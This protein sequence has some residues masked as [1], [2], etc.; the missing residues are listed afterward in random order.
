MKLKAFNRLHKRSISLFIFIVNI[1]S[2]SVKN[3]GYKAKKSFFFLKKD[4]AEPIDFCLI[5]C[6]LYN[7]WVNVYTF[8]IPEETHE[9]LHRLVGKKKMSSEDKE[10]FLRRH[11]R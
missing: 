6:T 7:A 4:Y 8:S 2:T 10:H 9:R 5:V 11:T 3:S 1:Y